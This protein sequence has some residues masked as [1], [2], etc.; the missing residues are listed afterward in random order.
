METNHVAK[1]Y[2]G[3][4]HWA[5]SAG[6]VQVLLFLYGEEGQSSKQSKYLNLLGPNLG[7]IIVVG[8]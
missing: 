4:T 3:I 6:G 1:E 7:R 2:L 8:G 5:R